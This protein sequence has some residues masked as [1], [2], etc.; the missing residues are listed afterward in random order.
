M[1]AITADG[2]SPNR[3]YFD[4]HKLENQENFKDDVVYWTY[5]LWIPLRKIY[6]ICDV[7][8]LIK[9]T[10]N[11]IKNSHGNLNTRNLIASLKI[12]S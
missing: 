11:N 2:A 10:T 8:H 5:N 12:F 4:L 1:R 9:T 6:F 3:K 7:S